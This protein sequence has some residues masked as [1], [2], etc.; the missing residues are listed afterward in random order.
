MKYQVE[1]RKLNSID[2]LVEF[3]KYIDSQYNKEKNELENDDKIVK[4]SLY[5]EYLDVFVRTITNMMKEA[6]SSGNDAKSNLMID[7]S[8]LLGVTLNKHLG[9]NKE[10][11]YT[12]DELVKAV[13]SNKAYDKTYNAIIEG[14]LDNILAS[15]EQIEDI[16]DIISEAVEMTEE[17][18]ARDGFTEK[19]KD[20]EEKAVNAKRENRNA[21]YE[22]KATKLS[23]KVEANW[24]NEGINAET[25]AQKLYRLDENRKRNL[26]KAN[27]MAKMPGRNV[28]ITDSAKYSQTISENDIDFNVIET[29]EDLE[30]IFSDTEI[31]AGSFKIVREFL[32]E[33]RAYLNDLNDTLE[34][35]IIKTSDV[36]KVGTLDLYSQMVKI[37]EN[38]GFFDKLFHPFQNSKEKKLINE[39]HQDLIAKGV[40]EEE[41]EAST[42]AD[43]DISKAI[44]DLALKNGLKNLKDTR[45]N[46]EVKEI[47]NNN[48]SN[49]QAQVT[50]SK[51]LDLEKSTDSSLTK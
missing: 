10:V 43:F 14:K 47:N 50:N 19:L 12:A 15:F 48:N 26:A 6:I 28:N 31:F 22:K 7:L 40:S 34:D 8:R 33:K 20:K 18:E 3:K 46:I 41:I 2:D 39:L 25:N 32:S 5:G 30:R 13:N 4:E 37:R 9:Y 42:S 17:Y 21:S 51:N 45:T 36:L 23:T 24:N 1:N 11:F 29:K 16:D 49:L 38:R 35:G 44:D 27:K